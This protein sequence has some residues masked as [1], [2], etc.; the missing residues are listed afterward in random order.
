MP[1]QPNFLERF[2]FHNLNLAP[3]IM[4]DIAGVLAYQHDG[5]CQVKVMK[6]AAE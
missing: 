4:L 5:R 3:A 2:A 6:V 1:V